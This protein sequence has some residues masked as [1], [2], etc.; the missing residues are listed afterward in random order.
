MHRM[1]GILLLAALAAACDGGTNNSHVI[2]ANAFTKQ[3]SQ[4]R[5]ARWQVRASA[6]GDDCT[7]LLVQTSIILED[8]LVEALHYGTG[9][10]A[11][12]K[13]G[14]QQFYREGAFRAV[15]YRDSTGRVWTYGA[16][17]AAEA[18]SLKPCH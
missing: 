2:A 12:Y 15:A 10:Y 16:T 6:A 13:G 3:Y 5:L 18:Q 14:V 11:V 8:S 9:A 1:L 4:S 17:T 7:I